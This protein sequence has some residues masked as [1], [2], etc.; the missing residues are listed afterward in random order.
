MTL[1]NR[2]HRRM[3]TVAALA[4]ALVALACGTDDKRVGSGTSAEQT[5][6]VPTTASTT[7]SPAPTATAQLRPFLDMAAAA[8]RDLAE[9]AERINA[10]A[11]GETITY[12]ERTVEL[13]DIDLRALGAALPAGMPDELEQHALLVYSD[14]VSRWAAM[15]SGPC[16]HDV[17]TRPRS[18]YDENHCFISGAAAAA[19]TD[20]DLA[21][22]EA[23][24]ARTPRF[25]VA[26]PASRPAEAL[27]ARLRSVDLRNLGCASTGGFVATEPITVTWDP[28]PGMEGLPDW[29]GRVD[30]IQFYGTYDAA[31]GWEIWINAC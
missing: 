23:V 10:A 29:E 11:T 21:G 2:P 20:G 31:T 7:I 19:R 9:A 12:D 4:M 13:L 24:A 22:L 26:D 30:G 14:L 8:D 3:V 1:P 25:P 17:G 27:A 5:T 18:D 28:S 15:S 16:P 6:V